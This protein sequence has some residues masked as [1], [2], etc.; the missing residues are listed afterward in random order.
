MT[1][2]KEIREKEVSGIR[3]VRNHKDTVFRMLFRDKEKLLSLF[4]AVN[5]TDY[6]D[7]EELQINVLENALYMNMKND[8]SCVLDAR[9]N[10]YEHQS[11][12]NPNMPL[13]DLFYI[14]RMY[15]TMI[16]KEEIYGS[17]AVKLPTPRFV[18]FYNGKDEQPERK[19]MYLSNLY[20]KQ[21]GEPGLELAVVQL[22]INKGYN[23]E[24]KKNC[25]PLLGYMA[26]V[27][28]VGRYQKDMGIEEAVD[29]SVT[30]CI[31]EG[32]LADFFQKNRAEVV[33]MSIFEYD[34]EAH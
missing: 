1:E 21:V 26:Y 31:R 14:S 29:R 12:V 28:K 16:R 30:E 18:V 10:L 22:N 23:E 11:T 33:Q 4:N 6:E 25:E 2:E 9:L 13:R 34:E 17:K 7:P 20:A 5:G 24:L 8:M 27:E 32:I 3:V 19:V 15:E